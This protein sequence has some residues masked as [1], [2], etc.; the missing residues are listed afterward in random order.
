MQRKLGGDDDITAQTKYAPP[1]GYAHVDDHPSNLDPKEMHELLIG[2]KY[3][4]SNFGGPKLSPEM[5]VR[6][7]G[8]LCPLDAKIGA[9]KICE[10]HWKSTAIYDGDAWIFFCY[11]FF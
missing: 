3:L 8:K 9:P 6:M 11:M 7:I 5:R 1:T 10:D 2:R 4:I